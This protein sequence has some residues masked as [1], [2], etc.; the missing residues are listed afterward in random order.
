MERRRVINGMVGL[1]LVGTV[2][3]LGDDPL[4]AAN[5]YGY[6]TLEVD[7]VAVPLAPVTDVFEWYEHE[8][9]LFLDTRSEGAFE[10]LRIAGA[11]LSPAPDGLGDTD[12]IQE[13][14]ADTKVVTYCVCPH[15]LATR[16]GANTIRNGYR[17]TYALD[18]GLQGW[19]DEGYPI[20]G[21]AVDD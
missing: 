19:I 6:D 4:E 12:P 3:C 11:E 21:T 15:T 14:D 10:E 1:T 16:R 17:H 2:G 20:A 5:A 8:N 13:V 9:V 7:G 18:E